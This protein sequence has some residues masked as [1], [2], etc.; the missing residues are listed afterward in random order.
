M[1]RPC[2]NMPT[3]AR[4]WV[5]DDDPD[6]R[7]LVR[8][9]IAG[10]APRWQV[11]EIA[12][13]GEALELLHRVA[14]DP[15]QRPDLIVLDVDMAG[16]SGLDVLRAAKA[17]PSLADIPV[18]MLT[19]AATSSLRAISMETGAAECYE[20]PASAVRFRRTVLTAVQHYLRVGKAGQFNHAAWR[21]SKTDGA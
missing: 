20:K 19:G 13:G 6:C 18:V 21:E 11:S 7:T 5:V 4:V 12:D 9:A 3:G 15:Q 2:D 10:A 1:P 8:D 16:M 17:D 14:G